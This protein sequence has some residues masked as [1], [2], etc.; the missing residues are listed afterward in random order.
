MLSAMSATALF[1]F[2]QTQPVAH[3]I[4]VLAAVAVTGLTLGSIRYRGI[5]LGTAGV[6]FA[7]ILIGHFGGRVDHATLDFVKEFG[8]VLFVFTIGMQLGPGFLAALR[9]QGLRLNL[10]AAAVVACGAAVAVGGAMLLRIDRA[11]AVGLLAGATTNTPSLGAAQQAI[12]TLREVSADR[13]A[14][15]ALAYAVAY[16]AGV[17]GIIGSLLALRW[18]FRIDPAREAEA[19]AA[20]RRGKVEQLERISLVVENPGIFDVPLEQVPGHRE[21]GVVVSRVRA[22][23][24]GET[25]VATGRTMLHKGDVL[26]AVGTRH[27]LEQFARIVGRPCTQDLLKAAGPITSRRVVV[28]RKGVLGKSLKELALG[29]QHDVA[30]TRVAR[31]DLEMTANADLRLRFGDV[32]QIV[33]SQEDVD[34]V[35]P[36]LGNAAKKLNETQFIPLFVGIALGVIV[37]VVPIWIPGIS[38]PVRLGLAGGPLIAGIVLS[39]LGHLRDLVWHMPPSVNLA[40]RELGIT[41]FLAAVGLKAGEHFFETV[42]TR[43]GLLW[44]CCALATSIIPPLLVGAL[45]RYLFNLNFT[46]LAGL[47]AGSTTDPPA[48]AFAGMLTNSDGPHVAYATVY[49]LTMMLR[50]LVAQGLA[51]WLCR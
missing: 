29:S 26:L 8:L 46:T 47:I 43:T 51:L 1:S 20:E 14:L 37:G 22:G 6:I 50:I 40:F 24:N 39:R 31:G 10:L 33:G 12:A 49:P 13:A 11:A 5:A 17:G 32:L 45:A 9:E 42:W 2:A 48:L 16:P 27:G 28:T 35:V 44:F 41:L 25:H 4:L 18:F 3:A 36:L 38:M 30:V 19:F 15:P 23:G 21:T 34:H 7:G